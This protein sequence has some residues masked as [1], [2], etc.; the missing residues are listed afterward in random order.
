MDVDK[1]REQLAKPFPRSAL[2]QRQGGGGK[3][4]DYVETHTVIHRLS[5]ACDGV[6]DFRIN[7]TMIIT[8]GND[9][10]LVVFGEL[11]I[12]GLGT[13]AGTGVQKIKGNSGEDVLKGAASDALKKAATLFGVA[14]NLYG[15]NYEAPSPE[16]PG[17]KLSKMLS[18]RGIKTRKAADEAANERFE[19][20]LDKLNDDEVQS[21]VEELE[22]TEVK[23][24]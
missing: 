24:F 7:S 4:L 5:D 23:P 10:N 9:D 3:M 1:M 22:R 2:K 18:E 12:P 17:R 19:K 14:L 20:T 16:L 8:I 13:R 21:W 6:W 15:E 11:T